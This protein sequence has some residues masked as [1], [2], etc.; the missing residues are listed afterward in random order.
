M[1][2]QEKL[3]LFG[4]N[5]REIRKLRG[6]NQSILSFKTNIDRNTIAQIE[7]GKRKDIGALKIIKISKALGVHPGDLF[8]GCL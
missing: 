3:I 5:I 7:G 2:D 1:T 4:F 8:T 6:L